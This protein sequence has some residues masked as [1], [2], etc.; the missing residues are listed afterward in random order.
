MIKDQTFKLRI[1]IFM[2]EMKSDL[3]RKAEDYLE[4]I[5]V[6]SQEKEYVRIRDIC[7]ELGI[8]PPTV[9]EMVKKLSDQGY[10]VYKKYEGVYLT[11]KG[12]EI[13]R[14]IKD[15]H[16]TILAFLTFIGVPEKIA[17][18]D[19]CIIE[20]DLNPKTVEQ[21]KNLVSFI[22][23]TPDNPEWLDNFMCFCENEKRTC[24]KAYSEDIQPGKSSQRKAL[25]LIRRM[26]N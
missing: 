16:S 15:R 4:A 5:F 26:G 25:S 19:A 23:S 22:E 9:V 2:S 21:I 7:K 3:S 11:P 13:G 14:V 10:L 24:C 1:F 20:H 18:D 8:K 12:E 17:N 6:I